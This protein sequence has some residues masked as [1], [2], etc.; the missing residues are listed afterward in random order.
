MCTISASTEVAP[1]IMNSP[2]KLFN[3][4][5]LEVWESSLSGHDSSPY[6]SSWSLT[7][8]SSVANFSIPLE[9][10]GVSGEPRG[11]ACRSSTR[12]RIDKVSVVNYK[13]GLHL[14]RLYYNFYQPEIKLGRL[15]KS[16]T[17]ALRTDHNG[18]V[19]DLTKIKT[20]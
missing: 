13:P 10:S 17:Q 18:M 11:N 5:L 20:S 2:S 8:L 12:M 6:S 4:R 16:F 7:I 14:R 3:V 9:I 19:D 15:Y 1:E